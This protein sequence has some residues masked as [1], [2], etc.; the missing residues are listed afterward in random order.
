MAEIE[1]SVEVD[2]DV[3]TAHNQWT[4]F[5]TFP[6]FMSDVQSAK[7]LDKR[8]VHWIAEVGGRTRE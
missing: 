2:V 7:Q 3:R 6:R 8:H 5:E 1:A 4:Q